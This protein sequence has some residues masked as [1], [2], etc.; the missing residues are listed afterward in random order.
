[1]KKED[2]SCA[3]GQEWGSDITGSRS[4]KEWESDK[5]GKQKWASNKEEL[6]GLETG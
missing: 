5:W 3:K 4:D 2:Y 6:A 1:V